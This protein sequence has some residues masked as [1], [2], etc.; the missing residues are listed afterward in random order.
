M[1]TLTEIKKDVLAKGG[2]YKKLKMRL[3]GNDAYEV[4]NKTYT[5]RHLIEAFKNR[6]IA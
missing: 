4:N 2:E 6:A 5:K 3:N 1:T